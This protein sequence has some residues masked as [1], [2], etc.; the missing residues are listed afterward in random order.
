MPAK[1]YPFI[2]IAVHE[3]VRAHFARGDAAVLFSPDMGQVLWANGEGALLFGLPSIYDFIDGGANRSDA[4]YR[5]LD[6]A[7]RQLERTGDRRSFLMRVAAGFQRVPVN[8]SVEMIAVRPGETAILFAAPRP[9]KPLAVKDIAA[10]MISGFDDPDTHMAVLD[11]E[12][13]VLAA[14]PDFSHLAM[15]PQTCR[16]LVAAAGRDSDWLVKR[17]VP[18]GKGHLPAAIGKLSDDPALYLLFAVETILGNLDPGED[19]HDE[20]ETDPGKNSVAAGADIA[21]PASSSALP[22]AMIDEIARIEDIA[23]DGDD[24][25]ASSH[26][27]EIKDGGP[28]VEDIGPG[29]EADVTAPDAA[30]SGEIPTGSAAFEEP[31]IE[32]TSVAPAEA[33]EDETPPAATATGWSSGPSPPARVIC[34]RPSA[35]CRMIPPC[36]FCLRWKPFWAISIPARISTTS[37]K[38]TQGRTASLPARTSPRPHRHRRCP[39]R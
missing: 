12:G 31:S 3:R 19:F 24:F 5:Q 37:R 14:S 29:A 1:L 22:G 4:A 30:M 13:S 21:S 8:A 25:V 23:A 20:T 32:E 35:N 28:P 34:L 11:G 26:E 7:A 18:T 16:A 15:T 38:R 2:D 33:D 6:A 9:G 17:P 36:I 39:A 10:R 27:A